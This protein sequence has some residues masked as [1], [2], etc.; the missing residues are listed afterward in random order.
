M[1][2]W[3]K[4]RPTIGLLLNQMD[5]EYSSPLWRSIAD[6]ALEKDVNLVV[7]LGKTID[8]PD[9]YEAQE[10][11]IY[12]IA[13]PDKLDGVISLSST[14]TMGIGIKRYLDF[15]SHWDKIPRVSIGLEMDGATSI[16]IDNKSGLKSLV[17]HL[18]EVHGFKKIG[19]I[20]G[21]ES[22]IEAQLRYE[23]Y[24]ESLEDH[25]IPLD[26][27][28]IFPGKFEQS[29]GTNAV[30]EMLDERK[31]FCEAL[32]A[33]NDNMGLGAY[34]ELQHRGISIPQDIALTGFDDHID[35]QYTSP[36]FTTVR[37]PLGDMGKLSVELL[38]EKI[39]GK[40][41]PNV[42]SFP[43]VPVIRQ[44]CGCIPLPDRAGSFIEDKPVIL[45][46]TTLREHF[47]NNK[48]KI[49]M[50]YLRYLNI[51]GNKEK[52]LKPFILDL[53]DL[54]IAD[55]LN[56]QAKGAF[57][58]RLNDLLNRTIMKENLN[59]QWNWAFYHLRESLL[60]FIND[61]AERNI[62]DT[63]A[64]N[65][66]LLIGEFEHRRD[67]YQKLMLQ[68]MYEHVRD[69]LYHVNQSYNFSQMLEKISEHIPNF[70]INSCSINL[71]MAKTQKISDI[72]WIV[73]DKSRNILNF[74]NNSATVSFEEIH[75]YQTME[76]IPQNFT[77]KKRFSWMVRLLYNGDRSLGY[78][79]YE[80]STQQEESYNILHDLICS[81]L[82]GAYIWQK[83]SQS[84]EN[85]Q[86]VLEE[87]QV[88]S[89]E[90]EES[91]TK[92]SKLDDMKNDFIANITHDFRSPLMIILNSVDLAMKYDKEA[93]TQT[94][95]R[96]HTIYDAS[97]KL[98]STI[99]RLLDLAKMD[100]EGVKLRVNRMPIR[101]FMES[102]ADFY[103]SAVITTN[104]KIIDDLPTHEIDNFY[105]DADKLEEILN[106]ILS[107]ALK[108][109]DPQSGEIR[110]H[111]ED[112][113]KA[114]RISISDNGI[115][116]PKDK[117]EAIFNRFEQIE[118][119]GNT[120]YKG[121]G[122]GLAFSRQLVEYLKGSIRAESQGPGKG[123][124]FV[125]EFQKGKD[126]FK[127]EDFSADNDLPKKEY[128]KRDE[129]VKILESDLKE[130]MQ[131]DQ[132]ETFF[133][134]LNKENEFNYKKAVI[135]IVEDNQYI[136]EIEK[137]YLQKSGY[138]NFIIAK[139]GKQG[140]E[141]AF[142]YRPDIILCDY[143]MP[144]MRGDQ[145]HDELVNNPDFKRIPFI[146]LTAITDKSIIAERKKKGAIAYL[147]KPIE[148]NEL[149]VTVDVHLMKYMEF[150][151]TFQQ[152]T[153]DELT[154]LNNRSN[155]LRLLKERI[156]LR[157]LRHLSIIFFDID[158]FKLFN[159]TYGHQTGDLV[160]EK[161]GQVV[162]NTIRAYDL[163]GRYGG[164][165]FLILLPET[166]LNQATLLAEKLRQSIM[167]NPIHFNEKELTIT[168]SF[169]VGSIIDNEKELSQEIGINNLSEIYEISSSDKVDWESIEAMKKLV[170]QELIR[171]VDE[172]L[173]RAKET[174]CLTCGFVS[175]KADAFQ[176][177]TCSHCGEHL[178][179]QGRNKVVAVGKVNKTTHKE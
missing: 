144:V 109:I 159:D 11:I 103:K 57:I 58:K 138:R 100:A 39:E 5:S 49:A 50:V 119:G 97:L 20:R 84:Q 134:D 133:V 166:D 174:V 104:I 105:S 121:T 107:N 151:E 74:K 173:Y 6:T 29:S 165:E 8:S 102:L 62:L 137:E 48:E 125:L 169:G 16:V 162:K 34:L 96:Y 23:A 80:L 129:L 90:L 7:F 76:I 94:L 21:P 128:Q 116:I 150:K 160:L 52:D 66:Q 77:E 136:R 117:L 67:G 141:A 1:G 33:S 69:L 30:K 120:R 170:L 148:E 44:S 37:Q 4:D 130:K 55:I 54:L 41:V 171:K 17:N 24:C 31:V 40:S 135:L 145:F 158:F 155:I 46:T 132:V 42:I 156:M 99:D 56:R 83:M 114:V 86:V 38:L 179:I 26:Q 9:K 61:L 25:S 108:F 47:K 71:F 126:I 175:A 88:R 161:V 152:A 43:A 36:P 153:I 115:G 139:D 14:L 32:V 28:L 73:P 12:Y 85:Q 164:E 15:Y 78:V 157:K 106:N 10:N 112:L 178:L 3:M 60:A 87:L 168:A 95:K 149:L 13:N 167:T 64:Q 79:L 123:A 118:S 59:L 75:P 113:E 163:P 127:Q 177:G 101:I 140:I 93:D 72:E 142:M 154:K 176:D 65:A 68:R 35:I 82:Q 27:A 98:K 19:I 18:I 172:A 110:I 63:I 2:K 91:N 143:N 146:F 111:L 70:N 89:D 51:P 53:L 124:T 22:N 81:A 131:L 92:L 122:I 147:G 45:T